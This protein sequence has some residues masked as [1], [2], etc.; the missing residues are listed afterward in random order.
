M[1]NPKILI[2]DDDEGMRTQLKWGLEGYEVITADSRLHAIEQFEL[3]H[4]PVVTLDLGLPPDADGTSEGFATLKEILQKAPDTKVVIVS[5]SEELGSAEKARSNGAFEYYPK[6]VELDRLQ[7]VIELAYAE[8][9]S[10]AK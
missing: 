2:V 10:K 1:N 7:Q 5:G 4:P 6:P 3:H 9:Q 8:Y